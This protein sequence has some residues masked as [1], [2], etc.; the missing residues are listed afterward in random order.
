MVVKTAVIKELEALFG[1]SGNQL[2]VLYGRTD[3]EKELLL[4]TFV[5]NKKY[6]Y[7]RAS[8]IC[9]RTGASDGRRSG[10]TL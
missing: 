5:Q 9:G 7:Y 8:G 4:K 10:T 1:Q 6:F 2:L 3:S